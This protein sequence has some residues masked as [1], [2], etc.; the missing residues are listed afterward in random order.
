MYKLDEARRHGARGIIFVHTEETA[1]YPFTVITSQT[2]MV[3]LETPAKN[4]LELWGWISEN[5]A[6]R[7]IKSTKYDLAKLFSLCNS[8]NFKPFQIS[9]N[10]HL[11]LTFSTKKINGINLI[12]FF[13]CSQF[14]LMGK[15]WIPGLSDEAIVYSAHHDH[16]GT[17]IPNKQGDKI[18]NG[19]LDNASGLS[20]LLSII[21]V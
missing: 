21:N 6:N 12:G 18:Y 4:N 3:S 1:G 10:F 13:S 7:L 19:A 17:G 8:R 15:G 5:T 2:E 9:T 16:L 14:F 11:D 20:M